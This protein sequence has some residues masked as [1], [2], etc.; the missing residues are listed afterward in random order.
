MNRNYI[1]S[2]I[3][4]YTQ[5][6]MHLSHHTTVIFYYQTDET[7][8]TFFQSHFLQAQIA[9]GGRPVEC[10]ILVQCF[11][12]FECRDVFDAG[13]CHVSSSGHLHRTYRWWQLI[14]IFL[15]FSPR[16]FGEDEDT[17]FDYIIFFRW[18]VQPPTTQDISQM[19]Q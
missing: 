8:S 10:L 18:V 5:H 19:W 14:Q 9:I 11:H 15:E 6:Q 17:H 7:N 1:I 4:V 16:F 3:A 2:H 12:G 13:I